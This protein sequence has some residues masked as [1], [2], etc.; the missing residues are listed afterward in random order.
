MDDSKTDPGDDQTTNLCLR[1]L[2][3]AM[4]NRGEER[5][6]AMGSAFPTDDNTGFIANVF[7]KRLEGLGASVACSRAT[8]LG[9][10]IAHELGHLLLGRNSHSE[11]GIMS[12]NWQR[13]GQVARLRAGSLLFTPQEAQR[14]S[15]IILE[16]ER[17]ASGSP[18]FSDL[19]T[20]TRR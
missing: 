19:V 4:S 7:Y 12:A 18:R 8:M 14:I 20:S 13:D 16:R 17:K 11:S 5:F 2:P 10:V 6:E 9:N 15:Y 3:G 1:I